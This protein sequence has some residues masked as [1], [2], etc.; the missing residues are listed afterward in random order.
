MIQSWYIYTADNGTVHSAEA[1]ENPYNEYMTF[2]DAFVRQKSDL[3]YNTI[4]D[5]HF[6]QRN[7]FGRLFGFVARMRTD[8][9]PT[10]DIKG[11]GINEQCAL[12]IDLET[13]MAVT[14][15]PLNYGSAAFIIMPGALNQPDVCEANTPLTY[16]NVNVQKLDAYF[17]DRFNFA[18][19]TGGVSGE[20]YKISANKGKLN[21]RDP[22]D[23]P[24]KRKVDR[25]HGK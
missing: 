1:L 19:W 21:N 18:T 15:G 2:S 8:H 12:V 23:P 17:A 10:A 25:G 6:E 9:G 24:N 14:V 4:I 13:N 16:S 11:I 5:T 7:R 3:L 22:Y 20:S